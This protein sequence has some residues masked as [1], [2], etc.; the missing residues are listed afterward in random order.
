MSETGEQATGEVM[1]R[2]QGG[3]R[4]CQARNRRGG[5]CGAPALRG[6]DFCFAHSQDEQVVKRR[7]EAAV[8]GGRTTTMRRRVLLGA[9]TFETP[10]EVRAFL[11]ALTRATLRG[12]IAAQRASTAA[13][14]AH[15]ALGI[16]GTEELL[17]RMDALEKTL[18]ELLR[19][20]GANGE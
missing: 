4:V 16:R 12:E 17:E 15:I 10:A 19:E 3:L 11:E 13:S 20:E 6:S 7:R 1:D 9:V 2:S 14:I 8:R 18:S 5:E